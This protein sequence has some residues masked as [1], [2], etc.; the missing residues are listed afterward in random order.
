MD[1]FE[2]LST[3]ADSTSNLACVFA[4]FL[5]LGDVL[6]LT[7]ALAAGKTHFVKALAS[8]L[9]CTDLVT[10]PTYTIANFYKLSSGSL[11]HIDLYRLSGVPEYRDLGLEEY[12][13]EAITVIEWGEMVAEEFDDY[14]LL[15][16][17][18]VGTN[19]D[20]RML[21]VGGVGKRWT[22]VMAQL[23][24]ELLRVQL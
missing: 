21:T 8:A 9:G 13:P 12:Y 19:I 2:I 17:E 16:F 24:N 1:S 4:P 18:F 3:N 10:S 15:K 14:L 20:R 11:L 7:G 5:K 23:Q 6:L 22:T